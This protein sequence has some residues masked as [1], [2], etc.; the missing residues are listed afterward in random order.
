MVIGTLSL[1]DVMVIGLYIIS[2]A[3]VKVLGM[4]IGY[5]CT[6]QLLQIRIEILSEFHMGCVLNWIWVNVFRLRCFI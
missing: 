3:C 1:H 4:I 6:T 5:C 2:H